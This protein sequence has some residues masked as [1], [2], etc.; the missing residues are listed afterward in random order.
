M[1]FTFLS[2]ISNGVLLSFISEV[3]TA[4]FLSFLSEVCITVFLNT[5]VFLAF[6]S[7][8]CTGVFLSRVSTC[9]CRADERTPYVIKNVYDS[10]ERLHMYVTDLSLVED[11]RFL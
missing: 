1:F 4:V 8:V 11:V 6:L 3:S 10:Y 9:N 7:E 5:G 2:K